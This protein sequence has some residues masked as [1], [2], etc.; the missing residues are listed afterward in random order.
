MLSHDFLALKLQDPA[1]FLH[2]FQTSLRIQRPDA[3]C[4]PRPL[5]AGPEALATVQEDLLQALRLD[6]DKPR[7]LAIFVD[8]AVY[9]VS[10]YRIVVVTYLFWQL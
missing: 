1:G 9:M 2:S 10:L 4:A 7:A 6:A 3:I 5:I 8:E